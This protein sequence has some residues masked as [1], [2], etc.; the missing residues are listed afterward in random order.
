M[1]LCN[2]RIFKS[3]GFEIDYESGENQVMIIYDNDNI[4]NVKQ[5]I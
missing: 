2:E 5:N 3:F 1:L 4:G